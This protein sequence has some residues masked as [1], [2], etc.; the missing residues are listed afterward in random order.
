VAFGIGVFGLTNLALGRSAAPT[1]DPLT[2]EPQL[3]DIAQQNPDIDLGVAL[4]DVASGVSASVQATQPFR[5]ASTTKLVTAI[6]YLQQVEA[7]HRQL[8]ELIGP[9]T[10]RD[11]LYQLINRSNNEAWLAFRDTLGR[12]QEQAFANQLGLSS[13]HVYSN[14][15]NAADLA[16]LLTKL[17]KGDLLNQQH[18][19]L[20][21]SLM[22]DTYEDRFI[23]GA[24]PDAIQ[25]F[26]KTGTLEDDVHDVAIIYIN[27]RPYVLVLMTNGQGIM[28]YDRRQTLI[29]QLTALAMAAIK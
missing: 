28:D 25:V 26:H 29:H 16:K 4:T 13:F 21:L 12:D 6:Y 14:T 27:K 23:P 7:G 11:Q 18:T 2:L 20:L 22:Q 15:I 5:A 9:R 19:D 3:A 17:A 8:S 24:V 1:I 10:A